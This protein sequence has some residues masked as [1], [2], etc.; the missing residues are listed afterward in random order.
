MKTKYFNKIKEIVANCDS[1]FVEQENCY[2]IFVNNNYY[3]INLNSI[4]VI[5]DTCVSTYSMT[6][7][8]MI[9]LNTII[10][11]INNSNIVFNDNIEYITIN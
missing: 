6:D 4:M 11:N 3:V 7:E 2:S 10:N 1:V 5:N 8:Q 9:E